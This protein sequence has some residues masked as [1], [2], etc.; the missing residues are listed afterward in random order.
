[1]EILKLCPP[2]PIKNRRGCRA[3]VNSGK[4]SDGSAA[5][6]WRPGAPLCPRLCLGQVQDRLAG[7]CSVPVNLRLWAQGHPDSLPWWEAFLGEGRR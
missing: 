1:M 6:G 3:A 4:V 2:R 5:G 7:G